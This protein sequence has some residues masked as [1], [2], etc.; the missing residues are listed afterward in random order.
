[1]DPFFRNENSTDIREFIGKIQRLHVLPGEVN[2]PQESVPFRHTQK[3]SDT[4]RMDYFVDLLKYLIPAS[5]VLYGMYLVVVSFLAKER[6]KLLLDIKTKNT[7]IVL[8]ARLQAAE[9]LCLLLERISPNVLLRRINSAGMSAS[10]LHALLLKEIREE[11]SHNFSQQ[12][13]FSEST[14]EA[15]QVAVEEVITLINQSRQQLQSGEESGT[16]LAKLIFARSLEQ[17]QDAIVSARKKVKSEL[18]IYF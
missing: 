11:F 1:M 10:E 15:V 9:R 16:D 8:P 2:D 17:Q 3:K 12:V 13:Y 6:E 5:L 14:W 7:D 18:S 4:K